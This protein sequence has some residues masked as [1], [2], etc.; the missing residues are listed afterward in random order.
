MRFP[1]HTRAKKL[2]GQAFPRK[3]CQPWP[4]PGLVPAID[5]DEYIMITR[6]RPGSTKAGFVIKYAAGTA[7]DI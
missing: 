6:R 1:V 4:Q 3:M 2:Q 5:L 7:D